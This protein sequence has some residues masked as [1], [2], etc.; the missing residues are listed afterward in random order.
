[1]RSLLPCRVRSAGMSQEDYDL[2]NEL[3]QL[4]TRAFVDEFIAG[5]LSSLLGHTSTLFKY[6]RWMALT[7]TKQTGELAEL[8]SQVEALLDTNNYE[9]LLKEKG[10]WNSTN[11]QLKDELLKTQQTL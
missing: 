1:M 6:I 5:S 3:G 9:L 4:T 2:V 11:K 7:I 10:Q 8:T